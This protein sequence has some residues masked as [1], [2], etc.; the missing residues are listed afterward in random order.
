MATIL[1]VDDDPDTVDLY[2]IVLM[3]K[4]HTVLTASSLQTAVQVGYRHKGIDLLVTDL[5]LT[6]GK[7]D[8]LANLM[9]KR[10][11]KHTILVTGKDPFPSKQYQGFDDYLIKPVDPDLLVKTVENCLKLSEEGAQ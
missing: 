9:G 8:A 11:P 7:G 5:H 4:G 6:D 10:A 2:S 1:V 3:A